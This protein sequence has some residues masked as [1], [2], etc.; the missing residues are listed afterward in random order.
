MAYHE[1][2]LL[3]LEAAIETPHSR[4]TLLKMFG[5]AAVGAA[6]LTHL[7]QC[8]TDA[9]WPRRGTTAS[10]FETHGPRN[11]KMTMVLPG[12]GVQS[13]EGIMH[14]IAP[15][16]NQTSQYA[17]FVRY[18]DH[19]LNI[20]HIADAINR[21]QYRLGFD[22]IY[23]YL[24]SMAGAMAPDI[25]SRLDRKVT[26]AGITYDCSPW[27]SDFVF[28]QGLVELISSIPIAGSYSTKLLAQTAERSQP[29][30]DHQTIGKKLETVWTTTNDEGSPRTCVGQIHY[31]KQRQMPAY[32]GMREDTP[33]VYFRP[34]DA[35]T[36]RT[37]RIIAAQ[38][39]FEASIPGNKRIIFVPFRG[40]ANP[41]GRP[42]AYNQAIMSIPQAFDSSGPRVISTRYGIR[43]EKGGAR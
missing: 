41:K 9:K 37:T 11:G 14:A 22:A 24:H 43:V 6:G 5:V 38:K 8:V 29:K 40:H 33:S 3:T 16:I 25:L 19:D 26:I 17:G 1:A 7:D 42:E 32:D 21:T 20:D 12:F 23:L 27:T 13:G 39:A 28:D 30:Y 31:L 10:V 15:S 35:E 18:G 4:R 2:P 36:D 34:S